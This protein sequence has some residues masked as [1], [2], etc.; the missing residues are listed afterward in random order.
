MYVGKQIIVDATGRWSLIGVECSYGIKTLDHDKKISFSF[1]SHKCII[2]EEQK[3][4][5][6]N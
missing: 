1:S 2:S 5:I 4:A 3:I 6:S